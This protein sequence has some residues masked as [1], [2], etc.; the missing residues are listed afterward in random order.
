MEAR[1]DS[2][3]R[4]STRTLYAFRSL[5]TTIA[6]SFLGRARAGTLSTGLRRL[7]AR[8]SLHGDFPDS[9]GKRTKLLRST[10]SPSY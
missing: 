7:G 9:S 6:L 1:A 5:P 3:T 10:C 8:A 2:F 4:R